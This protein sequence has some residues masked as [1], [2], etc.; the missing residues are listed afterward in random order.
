DRNL[1]LIQLQAY[2]ASV[3]PAIREAVKNGLQHIVEYIQEETGVTDD[4]IQQFI[5]QGFVAT[6]NLALGIEHSQE[7]WAQ[8]LTHNIIY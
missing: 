7:A 6:M 4:E 5:G 8:A 2:S 1:M 3:V